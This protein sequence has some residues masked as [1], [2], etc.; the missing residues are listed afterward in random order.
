MVAGVAAAVVGAIMI[1]DANVGHP[2]IGKGYSVESAALAELLFTFALCFVVLNVAC[3]EPNHGN[4]YYGLAIGFTVTAGA[5]AVGSISGGAFNPAVG[6]GLPIV[7]GDALYPGVT[8]YCGATMAGGALAAAAYRLTNPAEVRGK[9]GPLPF[10]PAASYRRPAASNP[11]EPAPLPA[12]PPPQMSSNNKA[13][14]TT[15]GGGRG[16]RRTKRRRKIEGGETESGR[17]SRRLGVGLGGGSSATH[18]TRAL[19][20]ASYVL[21]DPRTNAGQRGLSVRGALDRSVTGERGLRVTED[22]RVKVQGGLRRPRRE[23]GGGAALLGETGRGTACGLSV[24]DS[25]TLGRFVPLQFVLATANCVYH[26]H[27][28]ALASTLQ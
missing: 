25:S 26:Q 6:F 28:P 17:P 14:R 5:C 15:D 16:G 13:R 23:R 8:I 2:A 19:S 3:A 27:L 9:G 4:Q 22:A 1:E 7:A 12:V 20:P 21:R 11:T 18:S 24:R 10:L